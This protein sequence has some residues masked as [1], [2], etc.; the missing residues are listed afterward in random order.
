M[1]AKKRR[2]NYCGLRGERHKE[3]C[4]LVVGTEGVDYV[5]CNLCGI[6]FRELS[7]HL[8]SI[9]SLESKKYDGQLSCSSSYSKRVVATS[10]RDN[11]VK[12][13]K[14]T[15]PELLKEKIAIMSERVS[16]TVM[17]NPNELK[18]RSDLMKEIHVIHKEH[19]RSTSSKQ[20]IITSKRP[21]IL[22]QRTEV[23][24]KW[25]EEH[26]EEFHDKCISNMIKMK[27]SKPEKCLGLWLMETFKEFKFKPNQSLKHENFSTATKRRMIDV[28]SASKKIIVEF[29]G[30]VHFKNVPSWNQLSGVQ[31]RDSETN[32]VAVDGF[33]IIRVS[34]DMFNYY[35]GFKKECLDQII[36]IFSNLEENMSK[37]IKIGKKY[38][39]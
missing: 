36:D 4:L 15:N 7:C 9:H 3:T 32:S 39:Q 38:E 27:I 5:K 37:V 22:A 10:G 33:L 25:R 2:C 8:K 23:L 13:L 16:E 11:W 28:F 1:K 19:I 30:P 21:E 24:R 26:P 18:R 6:K 12:K 20:A 31:K 34:I 29:D 35:R 17:S 14:E